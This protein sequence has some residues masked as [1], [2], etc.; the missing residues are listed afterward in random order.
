MIIKDVTVI[1]GAGRQPFVATVTTSGE[2]IAAIR[3][4]GGGDRRPVEGG[5]DREPVDSGGRGPIGDGGGES[6]D[7]RGRFLV[8]GLVDAHNHLGLELGD[9]E[10]QM[11]ESDA[12]VALRAAHRARRNLSTGIT[13]MRTMGEKNGVDYAYRRAIEEGD[14]PGPRVQVS[15]P[16]IVRTGGHGYYLGCQVDGP[17]E[18]RRAVRRNLSQG[19][20]WIKMIVTGGGS[21]KSSS[22][23]VTEFTAEEVQAGIDEASAHGVPVAV[24]AHGG[25]GVDF[26]LEAG[27]TSIEHGFFLSRAQLERM[28][29]SGVWLVSTLGFLLIE[30]AAGEE[31]RPAWYLERLARMKESALAMTIAARETGVKIAVGQDCEHGRL[32]DEMRCLEMAGFSRLEAIAAATSRGALLMG[33]DGEV[34]IIEVGKRADFVLLK[35]NPLEDWSAFEGAVT[36]VKGGQRC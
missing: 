18:V 22:P 9:E 23:S 14:I 13:T 21:T 4:H 12:L 24:H 20:E 17:V 25:K 35:D 34:G 5:R 2:R 8:P 1:D 36:V 10:A 31:K 26:S 19:V 7:G 29:G 15:G 28:A 27:V 11:L 30:R 16:A 33:L 32:A 3:P 6:I